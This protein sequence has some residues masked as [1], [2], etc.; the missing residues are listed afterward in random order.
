[1]RIG[2]WLMWIGSIATVTILI[3]QGLLMEHNYTV[4]SVSLFLPV[5]IANLGIFTFIVNSI[6]FGLD[7][8]P[9]ASAEQ[10]TAFIHWFVWTSFAGLTTGELGGLL[11][12]CTQKDY[13]V[14]S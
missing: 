4:V 7:Q 5:I 11:Y 13:Q 12:T 2:L 6:S 3:L 8:M 1:M 9:E 10:I 14:C